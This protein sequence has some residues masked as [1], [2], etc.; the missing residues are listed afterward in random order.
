MIEKRIARAWRAVERRL[1]IRRQPPDATPDRPVRL[2]YRTAWFA[3][4]AMDPATIAQK[5][6]CGD[7]RPANWRA[8]VDL[9]RYAMAAYITPPVRG[10]SLIVS[11]EFLAL[12]DDAAGFVL[13]RRFSS[14]F[15]RA[16]YFATHGVIELHA[17]AKAE[18]GTLVR[19]FAWLGETGR[20]LANEG[21]AA[22]EET[23]FGFADISGLTL[24][25]ATDALASRRHPGEE[26]VMRVA[27]RWSLDPNAL[28]PSDA[29]PATG[30][31]FRVPRRWR[32]WLG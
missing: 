1:P 2:G 28:D 10:W 17:W 32:E 16:Q 23:E 4:P 29:G 5:L 3:V 13:P 7:A 6:G 9:S 22:S 30:L 15:G 8:G 12:H 20:V 14:R 24:D 11:D 21:R 31:L 18:S 19:H 27:A 25:E 26:D